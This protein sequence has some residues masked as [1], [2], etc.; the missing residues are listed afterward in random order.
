MCSTV[1]YAARTMSNIENTNDYQANRH[2]CD[3]Y[4]TD[5]SVASPLP[6]VA[7]E[8]TSM[9]HLAVLRPYQRVEISVDALKLCALF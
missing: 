6:H 5:L 9:L 2:S 4:D 3:R 7:T 1:V 8:S